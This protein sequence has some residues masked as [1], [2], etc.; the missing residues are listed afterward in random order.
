MVFEGYGQPMAQNAEHTYRIVAYPMPGSPNP[1]KAEVTGT[2]RTGSRTATIFFDKIHVRLDGDPNSPGEFRFSFGGG[3]ADTG[4]PLGN[5]EFFG[6][7]S[8]TDGHTEDVNKIVTIP[9]APRLLWAQVVANE[10]DSS[11]FTGGLATSGMK[12]SFTPPMSSVTESG[13]KG[14]ATAKKEET[15][16]TNSREAP[17]SP[18]SD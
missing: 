4:E 17:L 3:D 11:I 7:A 6:E 1:D 14:G 12:P 2:F 9:T 10:D 18:K 15:P 16:D 8:I 5:V 13:G